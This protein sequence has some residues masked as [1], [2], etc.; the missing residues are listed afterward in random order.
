M[1]RRRPARR[2]AGF[3]R[4]AGLA[5]IACS[6]AGCVSMRPLTSARATD[7]ARRDVCGAPG[8]GSDTACTVRSAAPIPGGYRVLVDR[9]PPAGSDRLAVDVRKGG[10]RVEVTP[11]DSTRAARP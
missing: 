5:A 2:A 6:L 1:I 11:I 10:S 4:R 3:L 9:R 7:I 8:T